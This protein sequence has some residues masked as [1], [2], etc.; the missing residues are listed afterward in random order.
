MRFAADLIAFVRQKWAIILFA[1]GVGLCLFS[2]LGTVVLERAAVAEGRKDSHL[3]AEVR[4]IVRE[5]LERA[6]RHDRP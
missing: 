1:V 6:R 5:E 2:L 3:G 4:R